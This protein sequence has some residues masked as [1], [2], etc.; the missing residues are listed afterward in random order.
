MMLR[1]EAPEH[2][3]PGLVLDEQRSDQVQDRARHE[4]TREEEPHPSTLGTKIARQQ[5]AP[6]LV[7]TTFQRRAN[8]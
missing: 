3:A 4:Q 1:H 8:R 7:I 6:N 5:F 2:L